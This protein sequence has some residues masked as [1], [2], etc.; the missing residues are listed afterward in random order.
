LA[1]FPEDLVS[2]LCND[3]SKLSVTQFQGIWYPNADIHAI[4]MPLHIRNIKKNF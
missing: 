3:S 2:I 1:A 4:K